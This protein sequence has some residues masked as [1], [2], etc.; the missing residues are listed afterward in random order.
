MMLS[1]ATTA[2]LTGLVFLGAVAGNFWW[3][4]R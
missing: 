1:F 3:P 4:P 2:T